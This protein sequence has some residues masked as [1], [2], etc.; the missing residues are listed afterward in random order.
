MLKNKWSLLTLINLIL[1]ILLTAFILYKFS[2][3]SEKI[4][5]VDNNKLFEEFR[6]T[7]EMKMIGEKEFNKKKANLDSLYLEIQRED[8]SKETKE[9]M[10]KEFV[11]KREEFDQFNQVFAIEESEKI[12]SRITSY[13]K[14]FSKENNY[15]IIIGSSD[16]RNILFA[17]DSLDVT[18]QLLAY[19]NKKY[20]GL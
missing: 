6:M 4:V 9:V 20:S 3:S 18:K 16:K 14:D 1:V 15:K 8:L 10:M 17:D 7:K 11:S 5:Y 19:I 13:S 2:N 12:W